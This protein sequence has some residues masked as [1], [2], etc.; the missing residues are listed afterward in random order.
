MRQKLLFVCAAIL[1]AVVSL[2]PVH[3]QVLYGSVVGLVQDPSGSAVPGAQVTITNKATGQTHDV[4]TDD[5][6]RFVIGNV[7]PGDY[8]LKLSASGF[9]AEARTDIAVTVNTVTR[10]DF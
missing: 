1:F 3:A 4:K 9:R 7:L 2:R 10:L 8:N 6:G 5:G